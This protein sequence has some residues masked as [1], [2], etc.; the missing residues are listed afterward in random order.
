LLVNFAQASGNVTMIANTTPVVPEGVNVDVQEQVEDEEDD[1]PE[2]IEE[3]VELLLVSLSNADTVVRW[4][5]AKGIGRTTNRLSLEFG[6]QIIESLLE[7][8]FSFRVTDKAWHGGCLALAELTRR[9]LLLP[10][11]LPTVV[12]L[13]CQALHFEQVVG[14]H[15]V[16]QH[17]RDAACYVC[18]AF[19]R[20]YAPNVLEPFV[21]VIAC[22]LIQ[23][24]VYDRE[25]NCRRAAGAAMQEHVGRQG[26]FPNGI[27][28]VTIAD[29]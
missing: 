22:A 9:G 6:D 14:N 11:R 20:A 18:W 10:D 8:C 24:A 23:V 2:Q 29:Y 5:A 16:G 25:I 28:V 7:R 4:A 12:P 15:S 1:V 3:V 13:V 27:D 17:V 21:S 19:A 26:T